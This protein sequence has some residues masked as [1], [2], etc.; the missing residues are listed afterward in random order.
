MKL[1]WE[2]NEMSLVSVVLFPSAKAPGS[3]ECD[4]IWVI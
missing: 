3:C 1:W 2:I 4:R